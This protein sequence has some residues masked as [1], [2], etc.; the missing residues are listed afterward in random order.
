MHTHIFVLDFVVKICYNKNYQK[1]ANE[2]KAKKLPCCIRKYIST[3]NNYFSF[4]DISRYK[5]SE[6][7][8]NIVKY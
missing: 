7:P 6:A 3:K 1:V 5:R 8:A 2:C 4:T